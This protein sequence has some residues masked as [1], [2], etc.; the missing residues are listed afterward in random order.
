MDGF[1]H[2]K[3]KK[4]QLGDPAAPCELARSLKGEN[5]AML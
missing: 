1:F 2:E 4:N 3:S 5:Q